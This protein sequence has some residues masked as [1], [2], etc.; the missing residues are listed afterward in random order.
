ML[1]NLVQQIKENKEI[2]AIFID[3]L[4]SNIQISNIERT[5]NRSIKLNKIIIK[6]KDVNTDYESDFISES[7]PEQQQVQDDTRQIK[8]F[9]RFTIILQIF[10]K[11]ANNKHCRLQLELAFLNYAKQRLNRGK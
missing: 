5:I 2:D 9:D 6:E 4:L 11:K 10:A 7:E 8:V 1:A 3:T